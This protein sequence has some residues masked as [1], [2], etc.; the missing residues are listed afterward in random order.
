MKTGPS[1][2]PQIISLSSFFHII[3]QVPCCC[4]S[5]SRVS[6]VLHSFSNDLIFP[7][8]LC[9]EYIFHLLSILLILFFFFCHASGTPSRTN[10]WT[11]GLAIT[12][13]KCN[14]SVNLTSRNCSGSSFGVCQL[15]MYSPLKQGTCHAGNMSSS[16]A[17]TILYCGI[18]K[19]ISALK[20]SACAGWPGISN[21]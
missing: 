1:W 11:T 20:K 8:L 12:F 19:Y 15:H 3:G 6:T 2:V 16:M 18:N 21:Q 14:S 5:L 9:Y 17:Y 4:S 13:S 7:L 10:Y